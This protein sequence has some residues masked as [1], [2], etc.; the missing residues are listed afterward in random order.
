M[1]K[2]LLYLLFITLM[3]FSVSAETININSTFCDNY[4]C[5][6]IAFNGNSLQLMANESVNILIPF[7]E[8]VYDISDNAYTI[9]GNTSNFVTGK[10]DNTF[11]YRL[12]DVNDSWLNVTQKFNKVSFDGSLI[13]KIK[14]HEG[15]DSSFDFMTTSH[16]NPPRNG[17][18]YRKFTGLNI[19]NF[20]L[21]DGSDYQDE[22]TSAFL[23]SDDIWYNIGFVMDCD[24]GG[25]NV[26]NPSLWYYLNYS[27]TFIESDY[28]N[29]NC[30]TWN[31][32]EN[33]WTLFS[34]SYISGD[35]EVEGDV[36]FV[37]YINEPISSE[38][39]IS[40]GNSKYGCF[41][42]TEGNS[43]IILSLTEPSNSINISLT[44]EDIDSQ[45]NVC[46]K[47]LNETVPVWR[48]SNSSYVEL[49]ESISDISITIKLNSTNTSKTP[50]LKTIEIINSGPKIVYIDNTL[51]SDLNDGYSPSRAWKTLSKINSESLGPGDTAL[52]KRG[53][54]WI[55]NLTITT[56]GNS[57]DKLL[58]DAYGSGERPQL[59]GLRMFAFPQRHDIIFK[60]LQINSTIDGGA[61]LSLEAVYNITIDNCTL[62]GN[63]VAGDIV[64]FRGKSGSY[65]ENNTVKNS[66][67]RNAGTF[68]SGTG[69]GINIYGRFNYIENNYF[70]NNEE[71]S[72]Q[73]IGNTGI[74]HTNNTIR[75]NLLESDYSDRT[76]A[77]NMGWGSP[78]T[79][80]FNNTIIG[81]RWGIT[82]DSN[83][84]RG[85][86]V[87]SY[88]TI[89]N[90]LELITVMTNSFGGNNNSLIEHN[91][92]VAGPNTVKNI[93]YSEGS[94]GFYG[95]NHVFK[96]NLIYGYRDHYPEFKYNISRFDITSNYNLWF[97]NES[98]LNDSNLVM[99]QI[100][101]PNTI[102]YKNLSSF[103]SATGQDLNSIEGDP[104]FNSEY[105]PYSESPACTMS[106]TGSYVGALPCSTLYSPGYV[107]P[108]TPTNTTLDVSEYSNNTRNVVFSAL[109]LLSIVVILLGSVLI[110]SII[111]TEGDISEIITTTGSLIGLAIIIIVGYI[112][113]NMV[114]KFV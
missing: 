17:F 27:Q 79:T 14:W 13:N 41:L 76:G 19:F 97:D 101:S 26:P 7:Q 113:I 61:A 99:F 9:D 6:D 21:G 107:P 67:I 48:C 64:I 49:S 22:S 20:N 37:E 95:H 24:N 55:E 109:A 1:K 89:Y 16:E 18:R 50:I 52:L 87:I 33:W 12:R 112:V 46:Y 71:V 63:H 72:V 103:Q 23:L 114:S 68:E 80:V 82:I 45:T 69:V 32:T 8:G 62:E 40:C 92:L 85:G 108:A 30:D 78:N 3:C 10:E 73:S 28:I 59:Q 31:I 5:N 70:Y 111:K 2:I 106:D 86:S 36:Q 75:N 105:I 58:I 39:Y 65:S 29:T 60:N 94:G 84:S 98:I 91:T 56:S 83:N 43:T 104:L 88:N 44:T 110:I 34:N 15:T 35:S 47:I 90:S 81:H 66:I 96:N 102:N 53:E 42:E 38:E 51:G 11:A 54:V 4:E 25:G 74:Y 57:S 77:I 93:W 100:D